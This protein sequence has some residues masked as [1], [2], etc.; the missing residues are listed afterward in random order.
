MGRRRVKGV[1]QQRTH[2]MIHTRI[3]KTWSDMK[4]RCYNPHNIRYAHYGDRGIG[5]CDGWR[6]DFCAFRDWAFANGYTDEMTI[7]RFDLD[8][9]YSPENCGFIPHPQQAK[10]RR[11]NRFVSINGR[12]QTLA[13]WAREAGL[14]YTTVVERAMRGWPA[15]RLI[16][17][18]MTCGG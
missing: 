2:G 18:R 10:N 17:P 8:K 16:E 3:Y 14:P 4:A 12:T 13:D 9:G 15:E 6:T 1:L 11:M 5:V 7:E